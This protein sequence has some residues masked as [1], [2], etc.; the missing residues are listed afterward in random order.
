MNPITG[1]QFVYGYHP[2]K[3]EKEAAYHRLL[4]R[5]YFALKRPLGCTAS[6]NR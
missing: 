1:E 6:S 2:M 3:R 5:E 4:V